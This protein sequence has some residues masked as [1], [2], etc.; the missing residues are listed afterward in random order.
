[1]NTFFIEKYISVNQNE[2]SPNVVFSDL[3]QAAFR[4]L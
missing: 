4:K 2:I 1:M 3:A